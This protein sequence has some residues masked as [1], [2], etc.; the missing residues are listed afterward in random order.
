[1]NLDKLKELIEVRVYHIPSMFEVPLHEHPAQ[2][3]VFYCIKGSG[4]G[5]LEDEEIKLEVGDSFVAPAGKMHSVRCD[6]E[7]A[8]TAFL[9][10]NNRVICHCH[11]VRYGDIRKA[12]L[13][14]ARTVEDV[15]AMTGAAKAC[16]T[17]KDEIEKIVSIAC[18]CHNIS[19]ETVIELANNGVGTVEGIEKETGAGSTCGKCKMLLQSIV[20][21]KK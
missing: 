1:M 15:A 20:D 10:P 4:F 14:G 16:G 17:C 13:D 3:E 6:D 5:I 21:T 19:M 11:Q 2:D 7:I 8:L 12:M 9:V 18:S